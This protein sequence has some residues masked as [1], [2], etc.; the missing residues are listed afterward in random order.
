MKLKYYRRKR[1]GYHFCGEVL[2]YDSGTKVPADGV[3]L[4]LPPGSKRPRCCVRGF[5]ASPTVVAAN[6]Y[7]YS[8]RKRWLC[9]VEV[10]HVTDNSP[11][12]K[13]VGRA[14]KIIARMTIDRYRQI[15]S[16]CELTDT[17]EQGVRAEF[18]K[19]MRRAKRGAGLKIRK[20]RQANNACPDCGTLD[21]HADPRKP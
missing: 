3:W 6:N 9:Y 8:S 10:A 19:I 12:D 2:L 20:P 18:R 13:F 11:G 7:R 21:C 17:V 5:H 14:R 15:L 16:D 1:R 4:R